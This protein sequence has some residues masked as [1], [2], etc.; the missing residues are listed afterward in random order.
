M[1]KPYRQVPSALYPW[2][3]VV[4]FATLQSQLQLFDRQYPA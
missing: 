4:L 2:L 1:S 3:I